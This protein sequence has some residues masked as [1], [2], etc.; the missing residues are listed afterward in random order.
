MSELHQTTDHSNEITCPSDQRFTEDMD[1]LI[2][3]AEH[4]R[5]RFMRTMR[6]RGFIAMSVGLISIMAGAG[7]FGWL[8]LVETD[9]VKG[10]AAL[11]LGVAIAAMLHF[12]SAQS[13]K[14]YKKDYKSRFLPRMAKVLGGFKYHPARGISRKLLA[15]TG[16]IPPHDVYEAE[17]CFM[18]RYKGVK[19]L[20]SEARLKNKKGYVEPI[21]DG[22]FVLVEIPQP[23]L[24]G[25]TIISANKTMLREWRNSRWQSLQDTGIQTGNLSWDRFA[26]LSDQPA[27]AQQFVTENLLKE[28][29]EAAD[30]F[31]ESELTAALFGQKFI[32]MMIP[33]DADMFEASDIQIPITTKQH[34]MRCKKE[35]EQLLEVIDVF[36]LYGQSSKSA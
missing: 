24:K 8:F 17:D 34:A 30:I 21:F 18:G 27:E 31:N 19:V 4:V 5:L 22:L 23:V 28:L 25:H 36:G 1:A 29:A 11:A 35:I 14:A 13:L 15:K 10:L 9:L 2:R 6:G 3:E 12:W 7:G 32:F 26:I 33:Y 20:F 16:V